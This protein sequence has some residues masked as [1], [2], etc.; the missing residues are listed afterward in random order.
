MKPDTN[1]KIEFITSQNMQNIE[2]VFNALSLFSKF[3]LCM[4]ITSFLLVV[5]VKQITRYNDTC[6]KQDWS[7]RNGQ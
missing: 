7:N 2:I 3:L 4:L 6:L 5:V 1:D